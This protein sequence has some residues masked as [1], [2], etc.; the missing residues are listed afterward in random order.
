MKANLV[1][2]QKL[3]LP[4]ISEGKSF[5]I[6]RK[7]IALNSLKYNINIKNFRW[8]FCE[9]EGCPS[10]LTTWRKRGWGGVW[11]SKRLFAKSLPY[12]HPHAMFSLSRTSLILMWLVLHC[13]LVHPPTPHLRL[14][15]QS[16]NVFPVWQSWR[17]K[18]TKEKR[19]QGL[20]ALT[21]VTAFT[22]YQYH[23]NLIKTQ[24]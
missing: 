15:S 24:L 19:T 12:R 4:S 22:S 8:F 9:K 13:S 5:T 7:N 6:Q 21:Y 16:R 20:S 3:G 1:D 17:K 2:A 23:H 10:K 18:N 14:R 11:N